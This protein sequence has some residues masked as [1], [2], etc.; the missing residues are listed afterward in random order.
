[1]RTSTNRWRLGATKIGAALALALTACGGDDSADTT[2]ASTTTSAATGG[3]TTST[4]ADATGS[5]TVDANT[6]SV[7]EIAAALEANGVDNADRWAREVEEYR[8]YPTDDPTFA[9]LRDELGKYNPS[10][11]TVDQIV[12]SLTL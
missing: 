11:E 7:A 10:A 12:A 1:M 8:P 6:A 9:K 3:S 5:K 4:V 2:A